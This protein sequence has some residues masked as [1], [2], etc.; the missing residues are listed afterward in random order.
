[1]V[2]VQCAYFGI[3]GT[4]SI[5][6]MQRLYRLNMEKIHLHVTVHVTYLTLVKAISRDW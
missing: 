1:M 5:T 3:F 6:K 4:E 2:T